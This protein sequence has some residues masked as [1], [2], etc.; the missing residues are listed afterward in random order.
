MLERYVMCIEAWDV[1]GN[2]QEVPK[3]ITELVR[4]F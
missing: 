2:E 3:K 4:V 1:L